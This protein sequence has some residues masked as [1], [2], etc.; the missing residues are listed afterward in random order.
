M[1]I[2]RFT[3]RQA[4]GTWRN[5]RGFLGWLTLERS[6]PP[7]LAST[8]RWVGETA[9][10]AVGSDD[11]SAYQQISAAGVLLAVAISSTLLT[12]GL[13]LAA[14]VV[15]L[16]LFL[17]GLWRLVPAFNSVWQNTIQSRDGRVPRWDR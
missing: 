1:T 11:E 17:I 12:L 5:F 7:A 9:P 8:I 10:V 14:V 16:P 4:A 2:A 13:T 6:L 15:L 3:G